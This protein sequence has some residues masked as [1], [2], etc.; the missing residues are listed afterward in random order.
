MT[1]TDH[2]DTGGEPQSEAAGV[3]RPRQPYAPPRVL[4]AEPL[5]AAAA[6]CDP[7]SGPFGKSIPPC[8]TLGS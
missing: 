3:E 1:R 2:R 5:E 7:P 6:T 8:F 4:S